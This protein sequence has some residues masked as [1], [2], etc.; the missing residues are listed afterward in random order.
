M[1][2]PLAKLKRYRT[3]ARLMYQVE[4]MGLIPKMRKSQPPK[5]PD[6]AENGKLKKK[7]NRN[8]NRSLVHQAVAFIFGPHRNIVQN[9][10]EFT[11]DQAIDIVVRQNSM[12]HFQGV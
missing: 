1:H 7:A 4:Q 2:Q 6:T 3:V 8:A 5:R 10:T 12:K 11:M 9:M